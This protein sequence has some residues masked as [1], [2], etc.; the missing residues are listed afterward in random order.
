[1]LSMSNNRRVGSK[2]IPNNG[3]VATNAAVPPPHPRLASGLQLV[4]LDG[5]AALSLLS[6]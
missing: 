5:G 6:W 4:W 3:D 1:M 2:N